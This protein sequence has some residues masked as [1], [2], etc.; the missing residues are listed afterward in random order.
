MTHSERILVRQNKIIEML[1]PKA[2]W[3]YNSVN[4][5]GKGVV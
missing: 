1:K 4:V 2:F 5:I 3:R